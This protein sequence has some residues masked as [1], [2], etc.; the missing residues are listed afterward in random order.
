MN[1]SF[2]QPISKT[3]DLA[4]QWANQFWMTN[5]YGL[6]KSIWR[7]VLANQMQK[8]LQVVDFEQ[9]E[10]T[11]SKYVATDIILYNIFS[12]SKTTINKDYATIFCNLQL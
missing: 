3:N 10:E 7:T 1:F 5:Q 8:C 12:I 4:N 11:W 6:V 2:E 9:N